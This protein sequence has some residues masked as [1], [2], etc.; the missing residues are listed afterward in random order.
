MSKKSDRK[1]PE[2]LI[3]NIYERIM[4]MELHSD[5]K[6]IMLQHVAIRDRIYMYTFFISLF[7]KF[8]YPEINTKI[9]NFIK[10]KNEV[11]SDYKKNWDDI[12]NLNDLYS[13]DKISCKYITELW[14]KFS[15]II[16]NT[17]NLQNKCNNLEDLFFEI[18]QFF[19][20]ES[21]IPSLPVIPS[22]DLVK[23]YNPENHDK[24]KDS[25]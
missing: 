9:D 24:W 6:T 7:R 22:I 2:I 15:P 16:E 13:P 20:E 8:P 5:F 17:S 23:K 12:E 3:E 14:E 18:W 21:E 1:T 4:N 10:V 11:E 25:G 19:D